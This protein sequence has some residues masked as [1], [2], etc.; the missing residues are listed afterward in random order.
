M[1]KLLAM[2]LCAVMLLSLLAGCGRGRQSSE[3]PDDGSRKGIKAPEGYTLTIGLPANALVEFENNAFITWLEQESG[4]NIKLVQYASNP[5][6]A[7]AQVATEFMT[8]S[9][10]PDMLWGVVNSQPPA[11]SYGESGLIYNLAPYF[12]DPEYGQ[13]W[14]DRLNSLEDKEFVEFAE[15]KL[16]IEGKDTIFIFPTIESNTYDMIR[17]QAFI[18]QEWL[19]KLNL[20]MPTNTEELYNT[21]VAFR[22]Q[23]PNVNNKKDE[24][25][26]IGRSGQMASDVTSWIINMF[27]YFED[28]RPW[29]VDENGKISGGGWWSDEYRQALIFLNKLVKE[30]LMPDS[31]FTMTNDD[32]TS[33]VNPYN[34]VETVGIWLGHP[35]GNTIQGSECVNVYKAMPHW[36]YAVMDAPRFSWDGAVITTDCEYPD[37]C[38]EI[39][40]LMTSK[41]GSYRMRYGEKGVDWVDATPGSKAFTGLEAEINVLNDAW[42]KA[43][44]S[45]FQRVN[46]TISAANEN[47]RTELSANTT[48]W[49]KAKLEMMG[50][51]Y[52]NSW[53]RYEEQGG[54]PKDVVMPLIY[55]SE[56]ENEASMY[57]NNVNNWYKGARANFIKGTGDLN[58][59]ADDAQWQKY[60][61][62]FKT[63]NYEDW[64]LIAQD[65]YDYTYG[66][67]SGK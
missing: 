34:G 33:L 5:N 64:L 29:R 28:A 25:P 9:K 21:L 27:T 57:R 42:G 36:G 41:E 35:A 20:P 4:Y 43:T 1:K 51:C 32:V 11:L 58:N 2:L 3:Q 46:A 56:E 19:D 50:E 65:V 26:L 62:G 17:H 16:F 23:D 12:N 24:I 31:V 44:S 6:D 61:D 53:T 37:A 49:Q 15:K 39:L 14:W 52:Q 13:L 67:K 22:D 47:E 38:W 40:M 45:T 55:T 30:G 18:N 8:G 66:S 48:P 60:I 10:M 54:R 59:P 7:A 63:Q